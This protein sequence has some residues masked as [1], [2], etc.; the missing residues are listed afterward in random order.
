MNLMIAAIGLVSAGF[1]VGGCDKSIAGSELHVSSAS[2][3]AEASALRVDVKMGQ[4][5]MGQSDHGHGRTA[6]GQNTRYTDITRFGVFHKASAHTQKS[7]LAGGRTPITTEAHVAYNGLRA[8][9]GLEAVALDTIGRWA[10]Q[11]AMTNNAVPHDQ[12]LKAV[13]L[14]YA[15]QGAKVGWIDARTFDPQIMA[16]IQKAAR[17]GTS[18]QV[19]ALVKA[20]GRDGFARFLVTSGLTEAFINTLKMEPHYGGIM[21]ARTHG[22]LRFDAVPNRKHAEHGRPTAHH[23]NHLTVLNHEQTKPFMNDT[24]DWPQ[25][26]A[27]DAAN[28][29]VATY[30]LSMVT[31]G[32]PHADGKYL[33]K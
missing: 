14:F 18:D 16:D 7:A 9:F 15:M 27:L 10:F 12:D 1:L 23:L 5:K 33:M 32:S 4:V 21:H 30:F 8:F 24:F 6:S 13:G 31:L 25:W 11:N 29:V 3:T 26:A 20:H 28:A 17:L 22:G 2:N 19:M